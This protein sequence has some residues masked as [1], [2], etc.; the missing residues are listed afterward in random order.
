MNLSL[1]ITKVLITHYVCVREILLSVCLCACVHGSWPQLVAGN[2]MMAN[3]YF[4]IAKASELQPRCQAAAAAT[5]E[6]TRSAQA[7]F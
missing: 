6:A 5:A 2:K 3:C 4:C 1:G 7:A